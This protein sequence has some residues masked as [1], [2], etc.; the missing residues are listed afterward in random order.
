MISRDQIVARNWGEGA[1]SII[2]G[3]CEYI[4]IFINIL[5]FAW[6]IYKDTN[7]YSKP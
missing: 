1:Y 3:G 7:S 4:N 5:Y 6:D 2:R